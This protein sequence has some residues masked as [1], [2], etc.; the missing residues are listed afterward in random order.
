MVSWIKGEKVLRFRTAP[1]PVRL[2]SVVEDMAK[3][4]K[5]GQLGVSNRFPIAR[6]HGWILNSHE[7]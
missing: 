2:D 3:T 7:A 6:G 5:T 4:L 1:V